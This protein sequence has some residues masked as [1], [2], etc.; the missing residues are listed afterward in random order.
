[1]QALMDKNQISNLS[2]SWL[3]SVECH[4]VTVVESPEVDE[5]TRLVD[6]G[7]EK[8]A[9]SSAAIENP[10]LITK[11]A[12]SVGSQSVVAVLDIRKRKGLFSQGYE[13]L[14]NNAKLIH[15]AD[16][17][18]TAIDMQNLGAGEILINSIDRD[19]MMQGYDLDMA[20][21]FRKA[22]KVPITFLGGAGSLEDIRFGQ[23]SWHGGCRCRELICF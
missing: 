19:G 8:V 12:A 17:I 10:N 2:P 14:T 21:N 4:C 22:I 20:S 9:I 7:V 3:L 18:N 13:I 1:M 23:K 16:P 11:M 6:M 15:K 5:A